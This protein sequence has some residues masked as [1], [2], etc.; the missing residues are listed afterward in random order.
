MEVKPWMKVTLY[1]A[2]YTWISSPYRRLVLSFGTVSLFPQRAHSLAVGIKYQNRGHRNT[3]L[4][5]SN[6]FNVLLYTTCLRFLPFTAYRSS[7]YLS[8]PPSLSSAAAAIATAS[9][10]PSFYHHILAAH[11][12]C[13]HIVSSL[14]S[15]CVHS[16][17]FRESPHFLCITYCAWF[18]I[19][20]IRA[21]FWKVSKTFWRNIYFI[22][23]S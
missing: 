4:F 11:A 13:L 14:R 6:V 16:C 18:L 17:T 7:S 20:F 3:R 8:L 12:P 21:V 2:S 5:P 10:S 23:L 15:S 9:S 19:C 22:T 1:K